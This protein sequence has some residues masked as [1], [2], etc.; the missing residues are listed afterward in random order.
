MSKFLIYSRQRASQNL[1]KTESSWKLNDFPLWR[2]AKGGGGGD[3]RNEIKIV[4]Q[5]ALVDR[6]FYKRK[7]KQK[8]N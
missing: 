3:E 7:L 6:A 8:S 4:E 5:R 2:S 1:I